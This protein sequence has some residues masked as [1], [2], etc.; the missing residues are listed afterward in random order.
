MNPRVRKAALAAAFL[1]TVGL[2]IAEYRNEQAVSQGRNPASPGAP[3]PQV[4]GGEAARAPGAQSQVL[5]LPE[6][7]EFGESRGEL[8][9]PHSWEPPAPKVA[10]APPP[11]PVAPP[12]PYR[13][14]GKF[15]RG[16]EYSVM[17]SKGDLVFPIKQGETI[18]G[19]YRVESVGEDTV[20]LLYL[21]LRQKSTIQFASELPG[22]PRSA[23]V[24]PALPPQQAAAPARAVP[25]TAPAAAA[26]AEPANKPA[27]DGG[28]ARLH[29]EGPQRVRLGA[30]FDVMLKL[31]SG[32]PLAASPMQLRF[33]PQYLE[34][35]GMKAGKYF[36]GDERNF[37]YRSSPDGS[38]YVGASNQ[39]PAP[40]AD[41]ELLILTFKPVKP[42]TAAE[43]TMASL[44]LHG[45]AGRPIAFSQP[46]SFRTAIAP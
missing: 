42:A 32:Q 12:M 21:P 30:R 19:A 41:A 10:P 37:S 4:K 20:T 33:D 29:W 3:G 39:N 36:G 6:R 43:L 25:P 14:A 27:A 38:I 8:F 13:F 22:A 45:P 34:L 11:A 28:T 44:N 16:D 31:T 18:D 15:V 40:A 5:A 17:L 35:I 23:G 2:V 24:Q 9:S 1:G 46:E 26:P 7:P